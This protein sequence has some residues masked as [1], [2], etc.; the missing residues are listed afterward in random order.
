M[1]NASIPISGLEDPRWLL[2]G[3]LFKDTSIGSYVIKIET[4]MVTS[5]ASMP[6]QNAVHPADYPNRNSLFISSL[7]ELV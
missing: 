7:Q 2:T 4:L 1:Q 3:C 5:R 6:T